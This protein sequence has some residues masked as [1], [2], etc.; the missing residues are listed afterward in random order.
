[1][2]SDIIIALL[3]FY[4]GKIQFKYRA[5]KVS[6]AV[7]VVSTIALIPAF[8]GISIIFVTTFKIFAVAIAGILLIVAKWKIFVTLKIGYVIAAIGGGMAGI[9]GGPLGWI[10]AAI[11]ALLIVGYIGSFLKESFVTIY[12]K[13]LKIA[14]SVLL[15]LRKISDGMKNFLGAIGVALFFPFEII[16][17][18]FLPIWGMVELWDI[19]AGPIYIEDNRRWLRLFIIIGFSIMIYVDYRRSTALGKEAFID[20]PDLVDV[21]GDVL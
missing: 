8:I 20:V 15:G 9:F 17:V 10:A 14:A 13:Y 2:V 4:L 7:A 12:E 18:A 6:G 5:V 1:M 16:A 3:L 19:F 21:D 11:I